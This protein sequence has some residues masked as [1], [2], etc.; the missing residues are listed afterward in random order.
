[1]AGHS[2]ETN[3]T[4]EGRDTPWNNML[5]PAL[6]SECEDWA[7]R[8]VLWTPNGENDTPAS[9]PWAS[10][11]AATGGREQCWGQRQQKWKETERPSARRGPLRG[12]S[13]HTVPRQEAG[14]WGISTT[15]GKLSQGPE[16][17]GSVTGGSGSAPPPA[18]TLCSASRCSDLPCNSRGRGS[19]GACGAPLSTCW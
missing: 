5:G 12:R 11:G 2:G 14:V 16:L 1:M 17:S 7:R 10:V 9:G 8:E 19:P 3:V 13:T 4:D 6:E 18:Q 15:V